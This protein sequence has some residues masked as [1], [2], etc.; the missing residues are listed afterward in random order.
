MANKDLR[1]FLNEIEAIGELKRISGAAST[2]D[3]GGIVDIYMRDLGNPA[4]LFD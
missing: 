1:N 2:E 4:L 3:I